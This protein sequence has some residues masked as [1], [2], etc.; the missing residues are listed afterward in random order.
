MPFRKCKKLTGKEGTDIPQAPTEDA[1]PSIDHVDI[2]GTNLD[3]S[4]ADPAQEK[5][6]RKSPN[7]VDRG[8]EWKEDTESWQTNP[9]YYDKSLER[10][11]GQRIE[12]SAYTRTDRPK[13]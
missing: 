11:Q 4:H 13:Q 3:T 10:L 2:E 5:R 7:V 12:G 8:Y 9:L 1:G 6:R